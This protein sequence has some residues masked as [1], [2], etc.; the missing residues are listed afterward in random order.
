MLRGSTCA[1]MVGVPV[2]QHAAVLV[3]ML[4]S[5]EVSVAP[6]GVRESGSGKV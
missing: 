3:E 4:G 2:A 6:G 1:M 5:L